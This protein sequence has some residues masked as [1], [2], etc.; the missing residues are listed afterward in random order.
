MNEIRSEISFIIGEAFR[1]SEGHIGRGRDMFAAKLKSDVLREIVEVVSPL[2]EEVK[3]GITKN[4]IS[5]RAVDPAHVAMVDLALE[6]KAFEEYKADDNEIG[7]DVDKIKD[8]LKLARVNDI[9]SM[10][11]DE[12]KNRLIMTVGNVTRK[13]ALVDT[14]GM[15]D[16]KVPNLNL[17]AKVG[18]KTAEL[19]QGIRASESVSDHIALT[20]NPDGFEMNSE[21]DTDSVNLKLPKDL[22]DELVCKETVRSLFPLD[23]FSNMV[24][25][26]SG[27]DSVRM[28]IGNDYP[29]NMEFTIAKGNGE[30]RYLLAPR[31]ES[32]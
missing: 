1:E 11:H 6:K 21:G 25:A 7:L 10:N 9:I 27:A 22:L 3:L 14:A 16:P 8:V 26:I 5:I 12:D 23:Y 18:I 17:P 15:S 4:G 29:V 13:M 32:E 30:V 2:V 31:I 20:V 24:K 19:R 28:S